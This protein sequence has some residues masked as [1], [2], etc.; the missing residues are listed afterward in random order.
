MLTLKIKKS[1]CKYLPLFRTFHTVIPV[2]FVDKG[3]FLV[4]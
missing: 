4:I 2:V 1:S 3:T